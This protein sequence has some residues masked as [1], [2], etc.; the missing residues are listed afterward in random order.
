MVNHAQ[1]VDELTTGGGQVCGVGFPGLAVRMQ[2]CNLLITLHAEQTAC[3]ACYRCLDMAGR[4]V[5]D[6]AGWREQHG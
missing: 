6:Y 4:R 3:N 2:W 5:G 1:A